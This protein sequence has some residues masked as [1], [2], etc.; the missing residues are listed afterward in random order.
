MHKLKLYFYV[1][2]LYFAEPCILVL[3][4]KNVYCQRKCCSKKDLFEIRKISLFSLCEYLVC[5][6]LIAFDSLLRKTTIEIRYLFKLSNPE[7]HSNIV[8]KHSKF[9][10]VRPFV[11]PVII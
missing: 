11:L 1:A 6:C 9:S 5:H 3:R 8:S 10:H 7:R 4:I 2:D